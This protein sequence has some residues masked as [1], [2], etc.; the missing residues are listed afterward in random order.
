M[1]EKRKSKYEPGSLYLI[2][3]D[4]FGGRIENRQLDSGNYVEAQKEGREAVENGEANSFA[5]ARILFNSLVSGQCSANRHIQC[6]E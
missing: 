2:L 4:R 3:F 6:E 1:E 5:I